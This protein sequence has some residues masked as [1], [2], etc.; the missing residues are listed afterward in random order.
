MNL[1]GVP[2]LRPRALFLQRFS[3]V[4]QLAQRRSVTEDEL[5]GAGDPGILR[6]ASEEA[7]HESDDR[8]GRE[9]RGDAPRRSFP[10]RARRGARGCRGVRV[11][12]GLEP[13]PASGHH[14]TLPPAL[15][16]MSFMYICNIH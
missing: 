8:D 6:G 4:P 10:R 16:V 7:E 13:R 14:Q 9:T 11:R 3:L 12:A 1:T 2:N 5:S 15:C